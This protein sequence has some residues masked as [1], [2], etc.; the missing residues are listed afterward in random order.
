MSGKII[1]STAFLALSI[2]SNIALA[3]YPSELGTASDIAESSASGLS[4]TATVAGC[5]PALKTLVH[6]DKEDS[7][8]IF[9]SQ[10]S[11]CKGYLNIDKSG[12]A[13][14]TS[15][16][17]GAAMSGAMPEFSGKLK[18]SADSCTGKNSDAMT[19]EE[20]K[21]AVSKLFYSQAKLAD[22]QR[23]A[24][25][26]IATINSV[27]GKD[28]SQK[29]GVACESAVS[30]STREVCAQAKSGG[31]CKATA[32]LKDL[33]ARQ[34]KVEKQ[35]ADYEKQRKDLWVRASSIRSNDI[36]EKKQLDEKILALDVLINRQK[37]L[38]PW[39][40][41]EV[42]H[43]TLKCVPRVGCSGQEE[44]IKAQ[45]EADTKALKASYKKMDQAS[46]CLLENSSSSCNVDDIREALALAPDSQWRSR[47]SSGGKAAA[48]LNE[49]YSEQECMF[50]AKSD[51]L[52][53]SGVLKSAGIDA[54]LGIGTVLTGGLAGPAA[55][56]IE[57]GMMAGR[58]AKLAMTA[59]RVANLSFDAATA[60]VG[61]K[62][63]VDKCTQETTSKIK[64][65]GAAAGSSGGM[66]SKNPV[67]NFS[68]SDDPF[69]QCLEAS[70]LAVPGVGAGALTARRLAGEVRQ[71]SGA[72]TGFQ[73]S[74]DDF[75]SATGAEASIA[76][77]EML[78]KASS[79]TESERIQAAESIAGRKL[80]KDEA[81][82]VL[83][84]HEV[85]AAAGHG[86]VGDTSN[87][88]VSELR[89]KA[90]ILQ[91]AGFKQNEI[92]SLMRSG[93]TGKLATSKD[94]SYRQLAEKTLEATK[95]KSDANSLRLKAEA[96][97]SLNQ[98]PKVIKDT[99]K[100][101]A[102]AYLKENK[103]KLDAEVKILDVNSSSS[104]F[105]KQ[106]N[107]YD[108]MSQ[109]TKSSLANSMIKSGDPTM[110]PQAALILESKF[111]GEMMFNGKVLKEFESLSYQDDYMVYRWRAAL[112]EMTPEQR[113]LMT[114][115][116]KRL[117]P[118]WL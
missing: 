63:A 68:S 11:T 110:A 12:A 38:I 106:I 34:D 75:K 59:G 71:G 50:E 24:I 117:R 87:Y 17:L 31:A 66:C 45:L 10:Y 16:G 14:P 108:R 109:V 70:L 28:N 82:A 98:D 112:Q 84:A 22:G 97:G 102:Q 9:K 74:V 8:G 92:D 42:Y 48:A 93:V 7:L 76:K 30:Q 46:A 49:H 118:G 19:A 81:A 3:Q 94:E 99:Y 25:E 54:M 26:G 33:V 114:M 73:K 72:V 89:Q 56:A 51:Q 47:S 83:N 85:G 79:L 1:K 107:E 69:G 52:K 40:S 61:I 100:Q 36:P 21:E 39:T 35:I 20:Q 103:L 44:A 105:K 43:N 77:Q 65:S 55:V 27:L 62:S 29:L 53:A 91:K 113:N 15:Q 88:T 95:N 80:T 18:S 37:S 64:S 90:D 101:T 60:S 104:N 67:F 13:Y 58:A 78:Q 32:T 116:L 23:G 5:S 41:G 86:F 2:F 111:R 115:Q 4:S 57:E 6:E 96:M